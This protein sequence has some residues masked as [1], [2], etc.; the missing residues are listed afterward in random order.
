MSHLPQ[1]LHDMFPADADLMRKLK[2][3]DRHFQH[4][5]SQL[6]VLDEDMQKINAGEDPASDE[7]SELVH[8]QRLAL[9]DEI[10]T[11]INAARKAA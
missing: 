3:E 1:S 4:L 8:K 2:Q 7:R 5:A 6:E 11:V 10:A 9:L